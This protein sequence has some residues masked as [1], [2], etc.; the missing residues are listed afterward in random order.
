VLTRFAS[1][2]CA[3]W[4]DKVYGL[5]TLVENGGVY[6]VDY[7]VDKTMLLTDVLCFEPH[8]DWPLRLTTGKLLRTLLDISSSELLRHTPSSREKLGHA[9]GST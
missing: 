9:Q 1:A 3:D 7:S 4:H 6:A 8:Q 5:L 2:E